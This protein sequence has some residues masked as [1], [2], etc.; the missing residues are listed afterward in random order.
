MHHH[1]FAT[2]IEKETLLTSLLRSYHYQPPSASYTSS[3]P[4]TPVSSAPYNSGTT[5]SSAIPRYDPY[6]PPRRPTQP[7][8]PVASSSAHVPQPPV[9]AIRFKYSPFFKAERLVSTVIECPGAS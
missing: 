6:A 3:F 2:M 1:Y 4:A 7:A 8:A 9:P 5:L